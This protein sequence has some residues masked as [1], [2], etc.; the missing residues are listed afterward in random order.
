MDIFTSIDACLFVVIVPYVYYVFILF[1]EHS[2]ILV[3][4]DKNKGA[5]PSNTGIKISV[6]HQTKTSVMK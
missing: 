3:G 1:F 4:E 5:L 2:I 6:L